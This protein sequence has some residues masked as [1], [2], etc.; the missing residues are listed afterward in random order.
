MSAANVES[1]EYANQHVGPTLVG[2]CRGTDIVDHQGCR[3]SRQR[4]SNKRKTILL[5]YLLIISVVAETCYNI[6]SPPPCRGCQK[7]HAGRYSAGR[8]CCLECLSLSLTAAKSSTPFFS[9]RHNKHLIISY[10]R[11]RI[12]YCTIRSG[13]SKRVACLLFR[14]GLP[15]GDAA[16]RRQDHPRSVGQVRR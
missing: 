3:D 10:D 1:H 6:R 7:R 15:D 13:I 4:I 11:Q 9:Q 8:Q 16:V 2:S 12:C 5:L 14:R